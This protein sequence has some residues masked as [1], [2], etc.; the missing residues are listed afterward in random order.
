MG[1]GTLNQVLQYLPVMDDPN[2][3]VGMNS[4]DDAGVYRLTGDLAIIQTIDFFTPIVDDPYLYGQIAAANALSD[5]YAMGGTPLTAMNIVAFPSKKVDIAVLA[6]IL[7]GGADKVLEA[8]AVLVGG[9]SIDDEEPKYGLAVTGVVH[10][11]R[12]VTNCG[13]RPGDKL[14]LTKPLGTGIITTAI[15]AEMATPEVAQE[16]SR[17]MATLNREAAA[18]MVAVGV[19]ACTDITGFGLLGHGMEMARG[20]RVNLVFH[21]HAI[22]VLPQAREFAA[23]GLVPGGAYNNRHYVE[24]DVRIAPGV[25][26]ALQDILYDPQTSG[27]LLIAVAADKAGDLMAALMERGVTAAGIIGEVEAGPGQITVLP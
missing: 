14:I 5:V 6:E 22:P 11:D 1:P 16:V 18:A 25:P 23:M 7:R 19:H 4:V 2:L 20:S 10:P 3:L 17:W 21:A 26:E 8:G 15:K 13:A 24:K 12:I 9:H 27:G